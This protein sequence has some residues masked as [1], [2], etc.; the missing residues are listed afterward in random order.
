MIVDTISNC[1]SAQNESDA[2][3]DLPAIPVFPGCRILLAEDIE[4]NRE[5]VL[6]LLEPTQVKIDSAENGAIAVQ[7]FS[8]APNKYDMI[9]MDMQMPEMDGLTAVRNIRALDDP[10]A[11]TIPIVAMTANVFQEDIDRCLEAGMNCHL[12]KPLDYAEVINKLQIYLPRA[13]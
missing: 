3:E 13:A 2:R 11:K 1:L 5:I 12:G 8:E 6:T 9:F 7:M 4:I 10:K